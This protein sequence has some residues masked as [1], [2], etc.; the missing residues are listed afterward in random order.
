MLL[1]VVLILIIIMTY[2]SLGSPDIIS[3]VGAIFD[4]QFYI[5]QPVTIRV[6]SS[7]DKAIFPPAKY[8]Y[9]EAPATY[10]FEKYDDPL[11]AIE[12]GQLDLSIVQYSDK[13]K[14]KS[15]ESS[16][17][18]VA[19]VMEAKLILMSP[20][21]YPI[22]DLS[23]MKTVQSAVIQVS[24]LQT[25]NMVKDLLNYYTDLSQ[26]IKIIIGPAENPI[27]YGFLTV[28]PSKDIANLVKAEPMHVVT[29]SKINNG[30][31]FVSD[32]E[33]PFFKKYLK[34]EKTSFDMHNQGVKYYP[35]LSIRGQ[36]LYYPTIK[37]KYTLYA[38]DGFSD[39]AVKRLLQSIIDKNIM[40][41]AEIGYNPDESVQTHRGAREI[42]EKMKLYTK[43]PRKPIWQGF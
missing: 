10:T 28:H 9:Q 33:K 41:L 14:S 30:N 18:F 6:S 38:R 24:D 34:Y 16:T 43:E 39:L 26:E 2:R 11:S 3:S 1:T 23:D 17:T 4:P 25:A 13:S 29:M 15:E 12:K 27:M 7:I 42:Y 19:N 5:A 8:I 36:L 21:Q 22:Q 31:Y 32:T 35:G 20:N 40:P 37:S